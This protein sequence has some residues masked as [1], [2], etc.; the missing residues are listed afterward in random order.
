[1]FSAH[2]VADAEQRRRKVGAEVGDALAPVRGP[3]GRIGNEAQAA[4]RGELHDA[5]GR[6]GAAEDLQ[7]LRR[8]FAGAQ[9]FGRGLAF[10][11]AH[12]L[13]DDERAAQRHREQHAEQAAEA[14]DGD[15]PPV[16]ELLPV[17]EEDER[18]QREDDAGGDGAARRCA[19]GDD[20]VLEDARA[21]QRTAARPSR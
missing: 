11:E 15:H 8:V 2:D 18:R 17:A 7:A 4:R 16:V 9:H 3:R 14:A 21:A 20:V 5:A 10:G 1:M 12:L 13:L 19:G 6:G